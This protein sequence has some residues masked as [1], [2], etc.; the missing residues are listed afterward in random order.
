MIL[1][2]KAFSLKMR[3]YILTITYIHIVN[4]IYVKYSGIETYLFF[5]N[6]LICLSQLLVRTY[7]TLKKPRLVISIA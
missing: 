6:K 2:P 3:H 1:H 5:R 4:Q 7:D